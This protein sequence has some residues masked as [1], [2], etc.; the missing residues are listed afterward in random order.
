LKAKAFEQ[1][2]GSVTTVKTMCHT[3][4]LPQPQSS[5]TKKNVPLCVR[6]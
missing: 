5:A 4:Q 6:P 2:L 3:I 1:S